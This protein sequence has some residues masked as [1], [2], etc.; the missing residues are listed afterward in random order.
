MIIIAIIAFIAVVLV[1][2]GFWHSVLSQE[3]PPLP[4]ARVTVG[5][6]VFSA[7]VARTAIEQARGLSFRAGLGQN[8]G[9][10]FLFGSSTVR[11]FWMKDMNFPLDMIWIGG[12]SPSPIFQNKISEGSQG[13]TWEGKVLGF[14]E[15]A[16]PQ[17]GTPLWKLKIYSSPPGVDAVLEVSAGTVAKDDI[18]IGDTV[19]I[20][21]T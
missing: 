1:V 5:S 15:N 18:K 16:A 4:A 20:S 21:S 14:A 19:E 8:D 13:K 10:V 3:N 17:P 11:Y 6:A 9:M 2:F 12:G 7:E